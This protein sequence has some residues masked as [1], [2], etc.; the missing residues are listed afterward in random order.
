MTKLVNLWY[1]EEK[2]SG[3][4]SDVFSSDQNKNYGSQKHVGSEKNSQ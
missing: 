2:F 4:I 3:E 1:L